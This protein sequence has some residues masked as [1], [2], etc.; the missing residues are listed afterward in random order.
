M[1]D[2]SRHDE[3]WL[4]TLDEVVAAMAGKPLPV[5]RESYFSH[6]VHRAFTERW[7]SLM[8]KAWSDRSLDDVDSDEWAEAAD[9]AEKDALASLPV[10]FIARC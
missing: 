4:A 2:L 10:C 1:T 9:Q 7:L 3:P 8:D 6:Y 5:P